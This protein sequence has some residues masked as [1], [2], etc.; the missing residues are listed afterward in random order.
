L[1]RR[2]DEQADDEWEIPEKPLRVLRKIH[3]DMY[4]GDG[5]DDPS[6]TTRLDRI[7]RSLGSLTRALWILFTAC[8]MALATALVALAGKA[9]V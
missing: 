1:A 6:V 2:D 5:P 3:T 9:H 7:E 4:V 8:V